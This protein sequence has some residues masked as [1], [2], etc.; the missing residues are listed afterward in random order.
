M[1]S[2]ALAVLIPWLQIPQRIPLCWENEKRKEGGKAQLALRLV[3]LFK[4][5]DMTAHM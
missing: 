4:F 5:G 2:A 3:Q 1:L